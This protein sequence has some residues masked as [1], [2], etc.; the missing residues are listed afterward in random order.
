MGI[1]VRARWAAVKAAYC[2]AVA[3][4]AFVV[5]VMAP[6][7]HYSGLVWGL[8]EIV[9]LITGVGAVGATLIAAVAWRTARSTRRPL[10][11]VR[12]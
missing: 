11:D 1:I 8:D 12:G 7:A 3:G 2:A 5:T 4:V 6:D 9:M 10:R